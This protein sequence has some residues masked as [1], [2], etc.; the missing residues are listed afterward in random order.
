MDTPQPH[1]PHT[2]QAHW[3]VPLK[4]KDDKLGERHA[5]LTFR[6]HPKP[7]A[8]QSQSQ[9]GDTKTHEDKLK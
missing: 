1:L 5:D 7:H 6:S 8:H 3:V 4:T 2:Q 9:C